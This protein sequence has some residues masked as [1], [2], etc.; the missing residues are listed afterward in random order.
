MSTIVSRQCVGALA[1]RWM[2]G[3]AMS[4]AASIKLLGGH[5]PA[6]LLSRSDTYVVSVIEATAGV[7]LLVG[8]ATRLSAALACCLC[9]GGIAIAA[10]TGQQCGCPG[11]AVQLSAVQHLVIS[12]GV[13]LLAFWHLE[14]TSV[15]LDASGSRVGS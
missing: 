8:R 9:F 3:I 6:G 15:M 14:A 5:D 11:A 13:A 7:L 4:A 12:A 10:V 1:S 2:L